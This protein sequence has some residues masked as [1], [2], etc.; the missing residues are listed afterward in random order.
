[1]DARIVLHSLCKE[2]LDSVNMPF[3]L[4]VFINCFE[5]DGNCVHEVWRR[6]F[7]KAYMCNLMSGKSGRLALHQANQVC[8]QTVI[9]MAQK[10]RFI[11]EEEGKGRKT[12]YYYIIDE[13][14]LYVHLTQLGLT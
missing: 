9:D 10:A 11:S 1:M 5:A 6:H 4:R 8:I 14:F 2:F 12:A 7:D 13:I 3:G